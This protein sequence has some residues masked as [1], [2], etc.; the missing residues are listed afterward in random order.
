M[1]MKFLETRN[2]LMTAMN[3]NRRVATLA[4]RLALGVDTWDD[5]ASCPGFDGRPLL[6]VTDAMEIRE[7]VANGQIVRN[8]G[9]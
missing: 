4:A 5:I 1:C 9:A 3:W 6:G 2:T 8:R 7:A